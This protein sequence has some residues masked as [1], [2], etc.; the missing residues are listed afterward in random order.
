MRLMIDTHNKRTLEVEKSL[1]VCFHCE[2]RDVREWFFCEINKKPL[3][4]D[5]ARNAQKRCSV[6]EDNHCD[7]KIDHIVKVGNA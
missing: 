5:C 6:H 4:I 3:C 7:W 2:Q 1:L